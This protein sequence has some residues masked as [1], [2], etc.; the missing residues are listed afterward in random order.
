MFDLGFRAF[1]S[2]A[3][4]LAALAVPA[5]LWL[6]GAGSASPLLE[7]M[8]LTPRN[9]HIH[10]MIFGYGLAVLAGF[11]LTAIPNWTSRPPVAGFA[12]KVLVVIWLVGRLA[13]LLC[14]SMPTLALLAAL[15]FPL[16]LCML[17]WREVLAA[18]NRRNLPVCVLLT[19]F[20]G[21][22]VAFLYGA[23]DIVE[24]SSLIGWGERAGIASLLLFISLIG[25]RVV[26]AFSR[27]WMTAQ[28]MTSLPAISPGEPICNLGRLPKKYNPAKLRKLRSKE[29][30]LEQKV[31]EEL[32]ANI[33]VVE[34][35]EEASNPESEPS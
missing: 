30:G 4:L 15:A 13:L 20:V 6:L 21:A 22:D 2:L 17:C 24:R 10:E 34:P 1:F 26:P 14:Q 32:G 11:L 25:G 33:L 19:L 18:G 28:G 5:W 3:A 35:S 12:L 7:T 23:I 27:N 8:V 16:G 9:W 31:L 29:D